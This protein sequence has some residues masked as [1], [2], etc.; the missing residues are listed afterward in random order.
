M[1]AETANMAETEQRLEATNFFLIGA[2]L[3]LYCEESLVLSNLNSKLFRFH[4]VRPNVHTIE[5]MKRI[6]LI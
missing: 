1:I 5:P 4:C 2:I 3:F 6:Y